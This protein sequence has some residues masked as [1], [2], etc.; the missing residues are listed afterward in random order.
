MRLY[1][2]NVQNEFGSE[3][4]H[5]LEIAVRNILDRFIKKNP[6]ADVRDLQSII[7]HA[8]SLACAKFSLD[9]RGRSN[10]TTEEHKN[11]T[12]YE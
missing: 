9:Q 6:Q 10:L 3:L 4:D 5:R 1:E 11:A 7:Q 12:V 8:T 2:A